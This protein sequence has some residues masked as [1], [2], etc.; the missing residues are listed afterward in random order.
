M[1]TILMVLLRRRC[2]RSGLE[3]RKEVEGTRNERRDWKWREA[4]SLR[5][6]EPV[7]FENLSER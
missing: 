5:P 4:N 2:F 1:T 3:D 7:H 6:R